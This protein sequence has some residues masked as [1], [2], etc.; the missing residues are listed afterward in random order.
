MAIYADIIF[1][2]ELLV[3]G[4]ILLLTGWV[5]GVRPKP[6]RLLTASALGAMYTLAMLIPS[7]GG[8]YHIL[9]KLF[10]SFLMIYIS[11]GYY[12]LQTYLRDLISFYLISFVLAGG[13]LGIYYMLMSS[14]QQVWANLIFTGGEVTTKLQMGTFYLIVCSM[15]II[16][17]WMNF[18]RSKRKQQLM[19]QHI[20]DV[21]LHLAG[22]VTHCHGLIDTG[23]QLY[24]PLT[25]TPV[26][27]VEVN[28][29]A[30]LLPFALVEQLK[31]GDMNRVLSTITEHE[32]MEK[33][34][35]RIRIVPY[36]GVNR[37]AQFMLALRPDLV[38]VK[39]NEIVYDAAKVLIGFDGGQLSADGS[40]QA[41][42]HPS[43]M[44]NQT[45]SVG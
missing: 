13:L 44:I 10:I 32:D 41:I 3:D 39:H 18:V 15:V 43:L 21:E 36:R 28:Q 42:V 24:D 8:M 22:Q 17:L 35:D 30:H 11:F 4:I 7:L 12:S 45:S 23:N 20:A 25:K 27:I 40:Y 34:Q 1:L 5:R 2:R 14:S 38:R 6:W 26:M 29:L 16:Y 9:I 31:Q 33:W 37:N 19:E